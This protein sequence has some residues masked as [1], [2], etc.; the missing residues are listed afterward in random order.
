MKRKMLRDRN[1][2]KNHLLTHY[3]LTYLLTGEP[4]ISAGRG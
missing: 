4:I 3:P 1:L 2:K